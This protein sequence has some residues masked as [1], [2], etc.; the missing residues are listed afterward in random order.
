MNFENGFS[1]N[2]NAYQNVFFPFKNSWNFFGK[3][4]ILILKFF[5]LY[6][7]KNLQCTNIFVFIFLFCFLENA[8]LIY[9][10]AHILG[11]E[12]KKLKKKGRRRKRNAFSFF[13]IISFILG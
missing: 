11:G 10:Q 8:S 13:F 6:M 2:F 4:E 12:E 9:Q 7:V 3:F 1:K 5:G